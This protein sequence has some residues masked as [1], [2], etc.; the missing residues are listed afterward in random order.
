MFRANK[1]DHLTRCRKNV[2]GDIDAQFTFMVSTYIY[3]AISLNTR[4]LAALLASV[5]S[6]DD[7]L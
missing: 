7:D 1:R 5:S 6:H 3:K 4:M 2:L